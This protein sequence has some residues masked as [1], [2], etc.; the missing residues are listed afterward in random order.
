ME[1]KVHFRRSPL[2]V[3]LG[4]KQKSNG[5]NFTDDAV[6]TLEANSGDVLPKKLSRFS[7]NSSSGVRVLIWNGFDLYI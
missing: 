7:Y 3:I 6:S 5:T 4:G 1:E 2:V